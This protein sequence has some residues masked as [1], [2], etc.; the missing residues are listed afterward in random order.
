VIEM[1]EIKEEIA[2]CTIISKNYLA[3][4]RTFTDS[5]LKVHPKGKVFVLLIDTLDGFFDPKNEK[6]TLVNLDEIGIQNL[7][8]FCFKYTILE[9]N[10][11]AKAHFL[12]YLFEKYRFK[13]L[14]YFDPDIMIFN[15]LKNLW[16]LLDKKSILLT[17]H[18]TEPIRDEKKPSELDI[19]RS[20]S[21][22]LGFIGL[23]NT[24]ITQKFLD[25]WIPHLMQDGYS[26]IEKGLF[27]DQKW[28]DLVP[29]L[30]D[31]VFIIRHP[32]YN[33]A[34][35]NLM[36]RK[37]LLKEKK[38]FVNDK[39]LYFFHFSGFIPENIEC[40]SKHQNRFEL[41]DLKNLRNLFE[42]YRDLL[43]ENGYFEC[44][45]WNC[46]FDFF[47][48]GVKIPPQARKIFSKVIK[49]GLDFGNPFVVQKK[50]SFFNY[51]S[52]KI[53]SK[54]P[55]ITRLWYQIYEERDD[56]KKVFLDVKNKDREDFVQW[57]NSSGRI[58]CKLDRSFFSNTR[59]KSNDNSLNT[60]KLPGINVLGYFK[61]KFGVAESARNF[62]FALKNQGIPHVLNNL[63]APIHQNN[64]T[65][66]T[67]FESDNP[68]PINLMIV[69][70]DQSE[71]VYKKL[72]SSFFE[73]KYNIAVWAWELSE[74]PKEWGTS[75]KYF[76]EIW[77]LSNFVLNSVSKS[78]PIPVH[79]IT[80]PIELDES[81]LISNKEKFG[82]KDDFVFLFVFDYLSV[83]ERKNPI[84]VV[85]SFQNVFQEN[86]N[87]KLI[88][89][90][91]NAQKF[92][93]EKEKLKSAI[94]S[95]NIILKEEH[96][97]KD[98]LLSLLATSDC[99]VSLHRSEGLGL[100]IAE[101]MYAGK[102]VIAT[103]YGGNVDFMNSK[104]GFPVKYDLIQLEKDY[105]PYTKG[106]VWAEPNIEHAS[107]LMRYIFDNQ[108]EANKIGQKASEDIRNHMSFQVSG[109]EILSRISK[110]RDTS[111]FYEE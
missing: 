40:V 105:G 39:P 44:K 8:S 32:G 97:E 41:E 76:N 16:K 74:F 61:G 103:D 79:K 83:F 87:V 81:K 70:A 37:V 67:K 62:V 100:T 54:T 33:V 20:G 18:L 24:T 30:F 59:K 49:K 2:V 89:K 78:S 47:D 82:I 14:A 3:F 58:E 77:V 7:N 15:S 72:K 96:M 52:E 92:L 10:T 6:F 25:W 73:G 36:Q 19:M 80:C 111:R 75:F 5:F 21:F 63:E 64:D 110:L 107:K 104:N 85:K 102:P 71:I 4:A 23:A 34:Y 13:K 69:N 22:N 94:T 55:S 31:D 109:K 50:D 53:D 9:Q 17:P 56:L 1:S 11:G 84:A 12:K 101:A 95:K 43:V 108:K 68:F 27:T 45:K 88:I 98:E 48:N 28:I 99:L 26:D 29:S 57:I 66:F 86:D 42:M 90:S 51:L 93:S 60:K 91:I 106:N 65:T 38:I 35:W 46:K